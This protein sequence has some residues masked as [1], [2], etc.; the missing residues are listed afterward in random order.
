M[1]KTLREDVPNFTTELIITKPRSL[2]L[3]ETRVSV[4][5]R[6]QSGQTL[7]HAAALNSKPDEIIEMLL[8]DE[9]CK[10]VLSFEDVTKQVRN[11]VLKTSA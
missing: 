2:G 8:Q 9:N 7:F 6:I 10:E 1:S 3:Q 4:L 11:L 5:I